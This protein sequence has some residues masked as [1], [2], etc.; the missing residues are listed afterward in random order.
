MRLGVL[1][2]SRK[3]LKINGSKVNRENKLPS[4][5]YPDMAFLRTLMGI[6]YIEMVGPGLCLRD[7]K[8]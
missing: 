1:K 5:E 2:I 7:G 6:G 8:K 4:C 3:K